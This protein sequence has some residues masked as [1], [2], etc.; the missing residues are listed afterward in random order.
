MKKNNEAD[1]RYGCENR[2]I[3]HRLQKSLS[4]KNIPTA[5]NFCKT[6]K[7]LKVWAQEARENLQFQQIANDQ[8]CTIHDTSRQVSNGEKIVVIGST[9]K[10]LY[11][12]DLET[13]SGGRLQIPTINTAIMCQIAFIQGIFGKKLN[14]ETTNGSINLFDVEKRISNCREILVATIHEFIHL[15]NFRLNKSYQRIYASKYKY[16]IHVCV[17]H[18]N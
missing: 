18:N 15:L 1:E 11:L 16:I 5:L 14:F 8:L 13:L 12:T 4:T 3:G 6:L 9:Y 2:I 7:D 17:F 10:C